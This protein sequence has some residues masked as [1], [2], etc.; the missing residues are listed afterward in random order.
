MKRTTLIGYFTLILVLAGLALAV[1]ESRA[2]DPK[3]D[4]AE[5]EAL[6][7]T[8]P[9]DTCVV[10][11]EKLGGMGAPYDYI[12]K[13]KVNGKETD[14]LVRFCCR[15]CVSEFQ[16]EPAKYLSKISGPIAKKN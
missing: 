10:S 14:R 1:P 16:K 13:E 6:V 12:Y 2:E 15:G 5:I 7:K 3:A 9:L 8:Y 11:G 4:K